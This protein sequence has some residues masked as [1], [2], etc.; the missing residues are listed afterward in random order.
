MQNILVIM[1][2]APLIRPIA[3]PGISLPDTAMM[4]GVTLALA[5]LM[6]FRPSISRIAGGAFLLSACIYTAYLISRV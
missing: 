1:G 3:A 2:I 5:L 6:K 4:L